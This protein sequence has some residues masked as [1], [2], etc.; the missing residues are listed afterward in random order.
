MLPTSLVTCCPSGLYSLGYRNANTEPIN[1]PAI[2]QGQATIGQWDNQVSSTSSGA[3]CDSADD[4]KRS[5]APS[6]RQPRARS[7]HGSKHSRQS[8][9]T[10][11]IPHVPNH[12]NAWGAQPNSQ[13]MTSSPAVVVN[14]IQPGAA[15]MP[16]SVPASFGNPAVPGSLRSPK[17]TMLPAPAEKPSVNQSSHSGSSESGS[18]RDDSSN[19][20]G[21]S[22]TKANNDWQATAG[23]APGWGADPLTNSKVPGDW[24]SSGN[25]AQGT[26]DWNNNSGDTNGWSAPNNQAQGNQKDASANGWNNGADENGWS[27]PN[28]QAQGSQKPTSNNEWNN[29][30]ND[31]GWSVPHNQAQ[32]SQQ[33]ASN[34]G[35]NNN[36]GQNN[37][38]HS[39]QQ[40][41]S[42]DNGNASGNGNGNDGWNNNNSP[43]QTSG[44][45]QA[46]QNTWGSGNGA[47]D[48]NGNQKPEWNDSQPN[49][50]QAWGANNGNNNAGQNF[51]N[52][53]ATSEGAKKKSSLKS[54]HSNKA[55]STAHGF[56]QPAT[57][58]VTPLN[59]YLAT[60]PSM[61]MPL[62]PKPYWSIW[63]PEPESNANAPVRGSEAAEGPI[64]SVPAE[65][66]QRQMMSHQVLMS[67][68]TK[69]VHRTSRP[70][71]IDTHDNP[72]AAFTFH[73]R[74]KGTLL[75]V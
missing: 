3:M 34:S 7:N 68:P 65:I 41:T 5:N 38:N 47:A 24:G 31:N 72:Y 43:Q 10:E 54:K 62:Q 35:W 48:G 46:Q 21:A 40:Q 64:Y 27:A 71:Y 13:P 74:S 75:Y 8:S 57:A 18:K 52:G 51:G 60:G 16:S 58:G 37:A 59:P 23:A 70:K 42:W 4:K 14:V 17:N 66:A 73:Y 15:Y 56:V 11:V 49:H 44:A 50:G 53:P 26:T 19:Q 45:E 55:P 28:N 20:D 9:I 22:V 61:P 6:V 63:K 1:S 30:G 29:G 25:N 39:S 67:K 36:G 2:N 33:A 69:Y 12:N 32:G